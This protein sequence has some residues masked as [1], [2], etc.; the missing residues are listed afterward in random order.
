M[1]QLVD[2]DTIAH[3]MWSDEA[4]RVWKQDEATRV[5]KQMVEDGTASYNSAEDRFYCPPQ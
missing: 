5:W 2:V 4:T 1:A 3:E